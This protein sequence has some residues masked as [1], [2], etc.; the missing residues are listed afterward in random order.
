VGLEIINFFSQK[1]MK[2]D[3]EIEFSELEMGNLLGMGGFGEVNK[4]M[5]KGT[6]VAV[7]MMSATYITKDMEKDFREEV[8]A[9]FSF[10]FSLACTDLK[11]YARGCPC[12]CGR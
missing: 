8:H 10:S 5:W 4:A 3:W 12:M 2:G 6:E 7:K 11:S 9:S 1:R